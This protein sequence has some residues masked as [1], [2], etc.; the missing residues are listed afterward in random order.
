M[1]YPV[2]NYTTQK[3]EDNKEA[4]KLHIQDK[5]NSLS[6]MKYISFIGW[7]K[8]MANN[9]IDKHKKVLDSM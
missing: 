2:Y 5:I 8:E 9:E 4:L 3:W 6:D 7:T 1:K